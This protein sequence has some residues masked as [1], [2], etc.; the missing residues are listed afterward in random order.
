MVR[1]EWAKIVD[2]LKIKGYTW[3]SPDL[4]GT[5]CNVIQILEQGKFSNSI[6]K[7]V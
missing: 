7:Q 2:F 4:P 6:S 5:N 1:N 3:V